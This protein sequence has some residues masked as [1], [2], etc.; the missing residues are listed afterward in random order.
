MGR[1]LFCPVLSETSC[2]AYAVCS[3]LQGVSSAVQG[4]IQPFYSACEPPTTHTL[5]GELCMVSTP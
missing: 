1:V 3:C 5:D 4:L 2:Y